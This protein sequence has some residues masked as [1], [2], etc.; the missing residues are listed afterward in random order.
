MEDS[1]MAMTKTS[2]KYK[3]SKV[4]WMSSVLFGLFADVRCLNRVIISF[5]PFSGEGI[6]S[7]I[8]IAIFLAV[9]FLC[10]KHKKL[11]KPTPEVGLIVGFLLLFFLLTLLFVGMPE[12]SVLD[13]FV[14]TICAFVLPFLSCVDGKIMLR[15]MILAPVAGIFKLSQIFVLDEIV[16]NIDMSITYA[17]LPPVVASIVYLF[18]YYNNDS[19]KCKV[20]ILL[21]CVINLVY[22]IEMMLFGSR[23]PILAVFGV[24]LFIYLV[25]KDKLSNGI[26]TKKLPLIVGVGLFVPSIVFM[27]SLL[28]V[29]DVFLNRFNINFR[30]IEKSLFLIGE[31]NLSHYRDEI[32]SI[33][34]KGFCDNPILGN[35]LDRFLANTGISYPH[36]F[37]LQVLYDGGLVLLGVLLLPVLLGAIRKYKSCTTGEY[38]ILTTLMFASVPGALFSGDMWRQALLWLFFGACIVSRSFFNEKNLI[39]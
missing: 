19:L 9:F 1:M 4:V 2:S 33:A 38:A 23:G 28:N 6:M 5:L 37:V 24:L 14:F 30:F 15:T 32:T 27:E 10:A 25:K 13:F 3:V 16:G 26:K 11:I 36:N 35:G 17:F 29:L 8:F 31:N 12:V 7:Y 21:S 34:W 39:F 20:I 18:V 22:L